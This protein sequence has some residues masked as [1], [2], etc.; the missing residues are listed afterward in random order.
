MA[1]LLIVIFTVALSGG[2]NAQAGQ[3]VAPSGDFSVKVKSIKELRDERVIHQAYDYS[4]GSAAVATLLTH[5]YDIPTDEQSVFQAMYKV[6]NQEHIRKVGFSLLDIKKFLASEGYRADGYKLTIQ[7]LQSLDLPSL[8]LISPGGYNHFIVIR[9]I[10]N[11]AVIVADS[12]LGLRR[13][14]LDEFEAIWNKVVFVIRDNVAKG[15]AHFNDS[16]D[17]KALPRSPISRGRTHNHNALSSFTI[18]HPTF[19]EH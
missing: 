1:C 15:R 10:D 12:Q 6:G 2:K 17:L 7:Q 16:A 9:G 13:I 18:N 8:T 14:P 19:H 4:C 3:I 5:S 11:G